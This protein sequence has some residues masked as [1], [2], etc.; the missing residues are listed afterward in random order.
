M[1]CIKLQGSRFLPEE[2][3]MVSFKN[4]NRNLHKSYIV[5]Q[6]NKVTLNKVSVQ[7]STQ[8]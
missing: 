6:I 2:Y 8:L 5:L 3:G 4:R 1:V 7:I